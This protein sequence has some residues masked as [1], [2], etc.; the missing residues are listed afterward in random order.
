MWLSTLAL[1]ILASI[2]A[3]NAAATRWVNVA[4]EGQSF[5]IS[6][7]SRVRYGF[8]TRWIT[9]TISG[10]ADCTNG[11]FGT[12]PFP[13]QVKRCQVPAQATPV[14][15]DTVDEGTVGTVWD[16][17]IGSKPATVS[18][19]WVAGGP[20]PD[21]PNFK[22][23]KESQHF[24]FYSDENLSD[25]E[26]TQAADT[27]ENLVWHNL[28]DSNLYM[29]EPFYNTATKIKPS[30]H[31]SS[32]FG[33][34]GGAWDANHLSMEMAPAGLLDHWGLT[35]EFTHTWQFWWAA[36][37]GL[38]CSDPNNCRPIS[39]SHANYTAHQLPENRDNAHCTE[40]LAN[41]PHLYLGSSRDMY[42][43]W[44]FMEFLKDKYGP[45][46]TSAI[47]TTAG[48]DP[49]LN[50]MNSRGWSLSQL[51][52][53]FGDWAMHNVTW[54]YKVSG[55]GFRNT[56]GNIT[57]ADKSERMHRLMPMEALDSN[58][59]SNHRFVSPF[60]GAPQRFGY[61]VVRLYPTAGASTVTITFR[62]VDQPGSDADF[63]W[64]L[65]A[66]DQQFTTSRYSK[67]QHGLDGQLTFKVNAGE[68]LFLVVT[69]T[70]SV[71]QT[72]VMEQA[73]GTIWR[74]PYMIELTNAWPQGFQNGQRDACPD[75]TERHSNGG[76]CAP[77]G[78]P[79]SVYIG[80]YATVLPG[81]QVSG[82]ARVED[83]AIIAN[84]TVTGGTVGG[85]SVIGETG[86]DWNNSF[87][88]SGDAQV[89]TSFYPLGF[90][91]AGQGASGSVNLSG[92]VEYRGVGLNL[93]AGNRSGFVD[94]NSTTGTD[95][96]INTKD[97]IHWR[98]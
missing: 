3:V 86:A 5:D 6:G 62:G 18:G 95:S 82:N 17:S 22:L 65:V 78:T 42:C 88:V 71:Y 91:E 12:D 19:T 38:S 98:E 28:F 9:R 81:S 96:D 29:Q 56:Y 36:N 33:L 4:H 44:Q 60:Y 51:N 32:S 50:I 53:F 49:F 8:G 79:T 27:L 7:S 46:A 13:G 48:S 85:L 20:S 37:G 70:P 59:P 75:G 2:T 35:H 67:L 45:S 55:N 69:A 72:V 34:S 1:A 11:Y 94:A 47:F 80:P 25:A 76:G 23:V 93:G 24:A 43:N 87:S 66:T 26:L 40:M 16:T 89:R 10:N 74:Y 97:Q 84:G 54:D 90:F 31:I 21:H 83:E 64:G 14:S 30:I 63:R 15:N 52:D 57:L 58:W 77:N 41:V 39:E 92:D 68:P 61:N 73:Y